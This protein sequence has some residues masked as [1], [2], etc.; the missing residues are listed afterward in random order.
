MTKVGRSRVLQT[1]EREIH[2]QAIKRAGG[3]L[4]KAIKWL[5]V[6]TRAASSS[7]SRRGGPHG[8][9]SQDATEDQDSS[10]TV[11][12]FRVAKDAIL[13]VKK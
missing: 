11:V 7:Q 6:V 12:K 13:G 9:Q 3:N 5:G 1:V 2:A 10:K 8:L 4:K